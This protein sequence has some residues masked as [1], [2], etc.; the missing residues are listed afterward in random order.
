MFVLRN[1]RTTK[2]GDISVS[3]ADFREGD[4]STPTQ[5]TKPQKSSTAVGLG[6]W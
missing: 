1:S 6:D 2:F 4:E 5:P 3:L